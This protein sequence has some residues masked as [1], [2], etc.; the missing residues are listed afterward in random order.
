MLQLKNI[1]IAYNK[2][3][4]LTKNLHAIFYPG[5][6]ICL[7][8]RNGSGKTTLLHTLAGFLAPIRGNIYWQQQNIRQ[9]LTDFRQQLVFIA[10][11]NILQPKLTL[12]EN[13]QFFAQLYQQQLSD[14]VYINFLREV[15]SLHAAYTYAE[16]LSSGEQKRIALFLLHI[17]CAKR[18]LILL[19]EPFVNL[20]CFMQNWLCRNISLWQQQNKIIIMSS[21]QNMN[22]IKHSKKIC[23]LG[24]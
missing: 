12:M 15:N 21:H 3:R 18:N 23:L 17:L 4:Y 2:K 20:D 11:K 8:G 1:S 5:D 16:D 14:N 13:L 6:V 19:D 24:K 9:N 22:F 10:S 7:Q